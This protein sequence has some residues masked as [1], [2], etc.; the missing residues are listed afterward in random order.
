MEKYFVYGVNKFGSTW[1]LGNKDAN[2]CTL[3]GRA[4][5]E[6]RAVYESLE[7]AKE[8]AIAL[9]EIYMFGDTRHHVEKVSC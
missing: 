5:K 6:M 9:N 3:W 4:P 7:E 1:Y 8:K 2:Q